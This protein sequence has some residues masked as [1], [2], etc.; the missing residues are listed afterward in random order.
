MTA[1]RNQHILTPSPKASSKEPKGP[2]RKGGTKVLERQKL[3][4]PK[5]FKVLLHNDHY[6]TMEFVVWILRGIF[7]RSEAEA[8][9][10]MLHIHQSGIGIAGV[11]S[12][13][14]A[15]MKVAKTLDLAKEHNYPL[16]CTFEE[17]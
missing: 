7:R 3:K 4:K 8:T 6:T 10:I 14:V 9:E 11:Y 15:E 12:K 2:S 17:V 5:M 1:A 16:Q 13:G